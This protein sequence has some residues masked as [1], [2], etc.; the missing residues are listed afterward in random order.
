MANW[1]RAGLLALALGLTALA[2]LTHPNQEQLAGS[3]VAPALERFVRDALI[4]AQARHQ[5]EDRLVVIDIDEASLEAL[6]PWPWPRSI[7]AEISQRLLQEHG[8]RRVV[9][10]LVLPSPRD[11]AGDAALARMAQGADLVL[12]QVLDFQVRS[13]PIEQGQLIGRPTAG[14]LPEQAALAAPAVT[15]FLANH[16]GLSQAACA[17]NIGFVPDADGRLR[18]LP[19]VSQHQGLE[20]PS[21]AVAA[22][23]CPPQSTSTTDPRLYPLRFHRSNESWLVIPAHVLLTP[24][25]PFPALDGRIALVGASALGLSDR[26]S[27]PLAASISGLYVHASLLSELLDGPLPSPPNPLLLQ[28]AQ[29]GLVAL[30]ATTLLAFTHRSGLILGSLGVGLLWLGLAWWSVAQVSLVPVS[31]PIW[32][33]AVLL[34][35]LTPYEW[36]RDR[37]KAR[38]AERLLARYVAKPVLQKLRARGSFDALAPA[39]A[40]IVVLVADMADYTRVTA[41]LSLEQAATLTRS[42]LQAI[43][44]PVW[45]G[46]GTLDRYTGDGL[47]A[48]WGAPLP[49]E[50]AASQA[51]RAAQQ[52]LKAVQDLNERQSS[53]GLPTVGLRMGIASGSAL[54][55]D[56]GTR[57]RATYTAVGSCI[58]LAAR[59]EAL[60][61]TLG[62]PLVL[63][64]AVAQSI[65]EQEPA[66]TLKPLGEHEIRGIGRIRL[67]GLPAAEAPP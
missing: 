64:E 8:V 26:V 35:V 34:L 67:F 42:F 54:V 32:G 31:A 47:V 52:M 60:G 14:S 16:A 65:T 63:S 1:V 56:F 62:E 7:L 46:G 44:E 51:Y 49:S 5:P 24:G 39:Q 3:G 66:L 22:L 11:T 27:T 37:Q 9:L 15:G 45:N 50:T 48:F 10:D 53:Q 36:L 38:S 4:R 2:Q 25:A 12:A 29:L 19:L 13:Q 41:G 43:T 33:A 55:G 6:G 28:L 61:K 21:L 40:P 30:L 58:N 20:L 59:L 23:Q 57:Y 18:R 17:G